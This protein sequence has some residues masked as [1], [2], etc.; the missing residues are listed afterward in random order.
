MEQV[1]ERDEWVERDGSQG[2]HMGRVMVG[3]EGMFLR[4][5]PTL[6]FIAF[7]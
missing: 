7:S 3:S 1:R 6:V 5:T 4:V 2:T